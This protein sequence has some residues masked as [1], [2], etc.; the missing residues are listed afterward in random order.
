MCGWSG[1]AKLEEGEGLESGDAGITSFWGQFWGKEVKVER[2]EGFS[3]K[4]N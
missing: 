2:D 3:S 4:R 1:G